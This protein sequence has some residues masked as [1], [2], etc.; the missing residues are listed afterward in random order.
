MCKT[1]NGRNYRQRKVYLEEPLA[2]LF[3]KQTG[4]ESNGNKGK[5]GYPQG[6]DKGE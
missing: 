1:Q 6:P 3:A 2:Q 5:C 4:K